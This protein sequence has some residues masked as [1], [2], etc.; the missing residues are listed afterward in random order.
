VTIYLPPGLY[1]AIGKLAHVLDDLA[2]RMVE[3]CAP[4]HEFEIP[5]PEPPPR[6]LPQAPAARQRG[7]PATIERVE[8]QP[9]TPRP[10]GGR[11]GA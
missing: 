8:P 9:E 7:P 2:R 10:K 5:K 11:P 3:A 4:Y 6:T 1:A